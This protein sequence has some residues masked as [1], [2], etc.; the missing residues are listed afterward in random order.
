VPTAVCTPPRCPAGETLVCTRGGTTTGTPGSDLGCCP[1]EWELY[2]CVF[3]NGQ[4]GLACHNPA[5]GCPS[6]EVC[7]AGCDSVVTGICDG[8][9]DGC[10]FICVSGTPLPPTVTPAA[11]KDPAPTATP[12]A[13]VPPVCGPPG[14]CPVPSCFPGEVLYCAGDCP[15]GCGMICVTPT[16]DSAV[17]TPRAELE[18]G[19]ATGVP[20]DEVEVPVTLHTGGQVFNS[21]Q[22][23]LL[24]DPNTPI[25]VTPDGVPD[26]TVN[27]TIHKEAAAFAFQPPGCAG[28]GCTGIRALVFSMNNFVPIPDGVVVYTCRVQI[29]RD[30]P[31]GTYPLSPLRILGSDATFNG[32]LMRGT[33]GTIVVTSNGTPRPTPTPKPTRTPT[34]T[35]FGTPGTAKI[36]LSNI[37][38]MPG[39]EMSVAATLETAGAPVSGIQNDI[40]FDS[41]N[42]PIAANAD[43]SPDCSSSQSNKRV[44]FAFLP[45]P[46]T[47][48]ECT[49]V[50]AEVF[51]IAGTD[52]IPNGSVLYACKVAISPVAPPGIYPLTISNLAASDPIGNGLPL[53]GTS[54]QVTVI[55][56][57]S[58]QPT[59]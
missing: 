3:A 57:A 5:M 33:N 20:G 45:N 21:F 47:G 56:H 53:L 54:G 37:T 58:P 8:C 49:M 41:A 18:V 10:G 32:V 42:V 4:P 2:P 25:A 6:T 35:M 22:N 7:G 30:A 14:M 59:P 46:C 51:A 31:A 16:P 15:L 29:S 17:P 50:R 28:A 12:G 27:G 48:G 40:T 19:S 44:V 43:G 34:P 26:C 23:D 52:L 1:E 11:V 55:G 24:F 9:S 38:G 36:V 13:C 39:D